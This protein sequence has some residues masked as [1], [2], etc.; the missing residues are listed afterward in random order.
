[1]CLVIHKAFLT[2]QI[3]PTNN[4]ITEN[5]ALLKHENT[6]FRLAE[7]R[8]EMYDYTK[9]SFSQWKMECVL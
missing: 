8:Q 9:A 4:S 5:Q 7:C 1:M 6:N 2:S 3:H